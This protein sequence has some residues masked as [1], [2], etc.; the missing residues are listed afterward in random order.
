MENKLCDDGFI[1][2]GIGTFSSFPGISWDYEITGA[3][4]SDG[5]PTV[6]LLGF[7]GTTTVLQ[8]KKMGYSFLEPKEKEE[9][10]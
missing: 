5:S 6:Q 7:S 4:S 8:L 1:V 2:S 3:A 9:I 10:W